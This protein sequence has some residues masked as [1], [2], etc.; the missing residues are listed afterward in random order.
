LSA[1]SWQEYSPIRHERF[2]SG[3]PDSPV[4]NPDFF[5]SHYDL[6]G[7]G[8][9]SRVGEKTVALIS[10]RHFLTAAHYQFPGSVSF[11]NRDGVLKTYEL[12]SYS[13]IDETDISIGSL[14]YP[15]P[16]EDA[17]SHYPI[18]S[19]KR[20]SYLGKEV[21]YMGQYSTAGK[22]RVRGVSAPQ[23][24]AAK[25]YYGLRFDDAPS[26]DHV[27]ATSGDSGSPSF[28][29]VDGSLALLGAHWMVNI[30]PYLPAY[31]DEIN[32]V[33]SKDGYQLKVADG[34]NSAFIRL[35]DLS[36]LLKPEPLLQFL[37]LQ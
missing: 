19:L 8:W 26:A 13:R 35:P 33:L 6:S 14:G 28:T 25:L 23:G 10:P 36:S 24:R 29:D 7:I 12:S 1:L 18:F 4:A 30:D 2:L 16:A 21:L 27:R 9:E 32:D 31:I 20:R 5:M 17:V 34:S 22:T 15:I 11:L 37:T 3:Y